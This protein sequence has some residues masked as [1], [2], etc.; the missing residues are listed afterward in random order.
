ME[1]VSICG[2]NWGGRGGFLHMLKQSAQEI[3]IQLCVPI[4]FYIVSLIHS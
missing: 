4:V 3:F 1:F 2:E